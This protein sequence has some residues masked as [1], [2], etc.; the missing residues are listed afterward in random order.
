MS[1]G[2][3]IPSPPPSASRPPHDPAPRES[4]H[5]VATDSVSRWVY[6]GAGALARMVCGYEVVSLRSTLWT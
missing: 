5:P 6:S 4:H 1:H 3:A 2:N